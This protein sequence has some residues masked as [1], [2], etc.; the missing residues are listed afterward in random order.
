V[1]HRR[2]SLDCRRDHFPI[3]REP[4]YHRRDSLYCRRDHCPIER[5]PVYYGREYMYC[6]RDFCLIEQDAAAAAPT[7][8]CEPPERLLEK[9]APLP[10]VRKASF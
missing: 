8:A 9:C 5:E 10:P 4:V 7:T 3:E 2:E 1:Y 6:R